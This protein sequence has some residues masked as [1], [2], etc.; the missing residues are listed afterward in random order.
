MNYRDLSDLTKR[1]YIVYILIEYILLLV[2]IAV[3]VITVTKLLVPVI[4]KTFHMITSEISNSTS[5]GQPKEVRK[6]SVT[7][8]RAY[9]QN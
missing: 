6:S 3:I 5:A 2:L 7:P 4:G 8:T 1:R 9:P